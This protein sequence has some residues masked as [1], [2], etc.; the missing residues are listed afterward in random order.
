MEKLKGFD[1]SFFS[2]HLGKENISLARGFE[3]VSVFTVSQMDK[4]LISE[5]PGLKLI[6][7]RATGFDN[8]DME[9]A[10]S[11]RI[12]VSNVPTYGENTVAEHTFG[13]IL[14]LSRKIYQSIQKVKE[15]GFIPDGLRGFDLK[16]KTLGIV[17][18]GHIGEHVARIANGFEMKVLAFDINQNKNLSKKLGFEYVELNELLKNSDIITLHVP[19][20][21]NTHHLINSENIGLIKKG[22]YLINTSRGGVLET[23]ALAKALDDGILSGA[24]LDVLEEE[25][26]LGE[27]R[28]LLSKEI[29]EN[30][31]FKTM[32]QN[33]ILMERENVIITPHN[34]F[35]SKEALERILENT[36]ENIEGFAD[37]KPINT[38]S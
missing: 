28:E 29:T 26:V 14:N 17:G 10:K 20:N 24:G 36:V 31:D 30:I 38:V 6:A 25:H 34:A 33:H 5:L 23:G 27:E 1:L 35:N 8:V 9:E 16:G 22:A 11:R 15:T 13:L 21:K 3:V 18:L 37:N 19:Y 2:E 4:E 7:V 12:I 32:L